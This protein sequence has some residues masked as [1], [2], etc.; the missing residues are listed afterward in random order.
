[1]RAD[2]TSQLLWCSLA[3]LTVLYVAQVLTPLR[4]VNDANALLGL[5]ESLNAGQGLR[6][7]GQT[8]HYPPGFPIILALLMK[9]GTASSFAFVM[10][11]LAFTLMAV[12]SSCVI[13]RHAFDFGRR[14]LLV[15]SSLTLLSW[16]L[17]KHLTVPLTDVPFLGFSTLALALMVLS[18]TRAGA[19][20]WSVLT[21]AAASCACA[22]SIRTAGVVLLPPLAVACAFTSGQRERLTAYL[23]DRRRAVIW[24]GLGFVA[25]GTVAAWLITRT[26]YFKEATAE[27]AHV[28][29]GN[30]LGNILRWRVREIGELIL[31]LPGARVPARLL[32]GVM[33]VGG[34]GLAALIFSWHQCRTRLGVVRLYLACY[35][36]MLFVWP[37]QDPR[38]WIP[39]VPLLLGLA[40]QL[41]TQVGRNLPA[42]A[43]L[44]GTG[45][46]YATF[47]LV[48]L[49]YSTRLSL[50][51][52]NFPNLFGL[53]ETKATYRFAFTGRPEYDTPEVDH[54]MLRMLRR[55][56]P[57]AAHVAGPTSNPSGGPP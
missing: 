53:P 14:G 37:Y 10:T 48:A 31:N 2:V 9:T 13:W 46:V 5:A 41:A 33:V 44:W 18:T 6:L 39:V 28:G 42:R 40:G 36:G 4:L 45:A 24:I 15:L 32:V 52:D 8:S 50:S 56:E 49:L 30:M 26:L 23:W 22:I 25:V 27:Y 16:P 11:N 3:G 21:A 1:M 55:Y 38:F 47:G 34:A 43:M 7:E 29:W 57:R 51:G 17:I 12:A 54:R 35:V 19:R 20:R